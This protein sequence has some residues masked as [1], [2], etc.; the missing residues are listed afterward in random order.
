MP[1]SLERTELTID[2]LDISRFNV[3]SHHGDQH[4]VGPIA[5]SILLSGLRHPLQVHPLA[6][7][8]RFG[9][10]AGGRRYR[11]HKQLIAEGKLPADH[12][13][14]VEILRGATDAELVEMSTI[15]NMQRRDLRPYEEVRAIRRAQQLGHS[16]DQV[17]HALG[18]T[19]L[20]I[21]RATRLAD[22]APL[23]FDAFEH[24]RITLAQAQAFAATPDHACQLAAWRTLAGL[25]PGLSPRLDA[26]AIRKALRIGDDELDRM[27]RYVGEDAYRAA[28]GGWEADL[29]AGDAET[30][31]R[32]TDEGKLRQLVDAKLDTYRADLRRRAGRDVRFVAEAPRHPEYPG[33]DGQLRLQ[34]QETAGAIALPDGDVVGHVLIGDEGAEVA[35]YW[36]SRKAEAA[37]RKAKRDRQ[38]AA[39]PRPSVAVLAEPAGQA[40]RAAEL[41]VREDLGT[42]R[43]V[44]GI[45]RS[46]RRALLQGGMVRAARA[47]DDVGAD[48]LAWSQCLMLLSPDEQL[49]ARLGMARLALPSPDPIDAEAHLRETEGHRLYQRAAAEL[50]VRPWADDEDLPASWR[51]YRTETPAM[52]RLAAAFAAAGLL[53]RTANA[54]GFDSQLH[55]A[56]AD[57]LDVAT[58][59]AIRRLWTPTAELLRLLPRDRRTEIA[60]PFVERPTFAAYYSLKDDELTRIIVNVVTGT[61]Y[62]LRE[63]LI[64][65]AS[66]WVHPL[67]RFRQPEPPPGPAAANDAGGDAA[68]APARAEGVA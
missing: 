30:R 20:V 13:I 66:T 35:W 37:A 46:I 48:L 36:A 21:K 54:E 3:R 50:N 25:A 9:V 51:A 22:L 12:G 28:G 63:R 26:A 11:A 60:E 53:E 64:D 19:P 17:A 43:D 67:L 42:T 16:V 56:L 38:P 68:P 27:L 45:M 10:Y 49:P 6:G 41:R 1:H 61:A 57:V 8:K 65:L 23:I 24:E 32:L 40:A 5:E 18:Q 2:Q 58:P 52:K 7:S 44:T 4:A 59:A 29:F 33:A 34:P 55:H 62:G 14:R 15:E 31:G 47:G 39:P